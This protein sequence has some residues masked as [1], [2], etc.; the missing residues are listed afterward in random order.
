MKIRKNQDGTGGGWDR[1]S[2]FTLIELL[3]VIAIIAILASMLLPALSKAKESGRTALCK[4][5]LRQLSLG[6]LLYAGDSQDTLPWAGGVDRNLEPDWVWGGHRM[7]NPNNRSEWDRPYWALHAESGS[8]FPYVTGLKRVRPRPGRRDTDFYTQTHKVYRCPSTG[9]LG[10]SRRVNFSMNAWIEPDRNLRSTRTSSRGVE[11]LKVRL[12]SVKLMVLDESP[13]TMHNASF[14]PGGSAANGKFT[15]HNG[16]INMGFM[17][18]HVEI[19]KHDE[20]IRMQRDTTR[21]TLNR[22]RYFDPYY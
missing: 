17:D 11:L 14:T 12:P 5:N 6:M 13:E 7:N 9:E 2:G 8:I 20:V 16:K 22:Y 18:G 15:Y 21:G 3:V 4:N 10:R 1:K 19:F